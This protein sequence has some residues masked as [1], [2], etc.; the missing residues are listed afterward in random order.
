MAAAVPVLNEN[1]LEKRCS[2][3]APRIHNPD[4]SDGQQQFP[5][6]QGNRWAYLIDSGL[7]AAC[8]ESRDAIER[9]FKVAEEDTKR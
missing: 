3:A 2:P 6:V 4:G 5:W 8:T 9:R 7:W 1:P